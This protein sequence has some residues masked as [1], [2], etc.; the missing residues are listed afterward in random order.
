MTDTAD[1][2]NRPAIRAVAFDLDG[3]LV[4]SVADLMH[5]SNALL[6]ELGRP[7]VDLAAVRSFVGDGAPK[8]VERVLAATGGVPA[9]DEAARCLERFLAIY[10]A[11]PSAHSTLYPGVAETLGRLAE[12]GLRLGV[13]TNKP[14]AATLR[15]LDDLGIAGRFAAVVGGDSYPSRKPSPEP[16]LGLLERLGVEPA[17]TVFVGDNEHDVA[18]AR[19][20]GVARVLVVPYGYARVP[21]DG[22]PHDGILG[23]FAELAERLSC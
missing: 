10:G 11:D 4:D 3:T 22:L 13:C 14:M 21:L 19:A 5:A 15:L 20:A 17:E 8:L 1:S 7:P 12:A 9:P 23:G 16:V 6:A 18:A 2:L